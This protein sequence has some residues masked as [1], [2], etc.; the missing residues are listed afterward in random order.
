MFAPATDVT[1]GFDPGS[2]FLLPLRHENGCRV[3][4]GDDGDHR[5]RQRLRQVEPGE[6]KSA[7]AA[8]RLP[9]AAAMK[10][11]TVT[12]FPDSRPAFRSAARPSMPG[13]S[14]GKKMLRF[15]T[16]ALLAVATAASAVPAD[17]QRLKRL[18]IACKNVQAAYPLMMLIRMGEGPM[19]CGTSD[20]GSDYVDCDASL[21]AAE[22]SAKAKRYEVATRREAAMKLASEACDLYVKDRKSPTAQAAVE[23]GLAHVRTTGFAVRETK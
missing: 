16:I 4:P 8:S 7:N 20:D 9:S 21:S 11:G 23:Q 1:P 3:E 19:N 18:D 5:Q 15:A 2:T 10:M 6:I 14:K 22:K 13:A 12:N 17:R